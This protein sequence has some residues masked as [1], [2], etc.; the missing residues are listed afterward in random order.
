M[1]TS[2]QYHKKTEF[3]VFIEIPNCFQM[4][5]R[6]NVEMN[7]CQQCMIKIF[8]AVGIRILKFNKNNK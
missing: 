6:Q 2:I 1:F 7:Y 8:S 5:C 4:P 3:I